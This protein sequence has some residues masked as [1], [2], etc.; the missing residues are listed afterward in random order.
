MVASG[1]GL[2]QR[3]T[4]VAFIDLD[5]LRLELY[6]EKTEDSYLLFKPQ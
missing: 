6:G 1:R 3:H 5:C 2:I 4:F